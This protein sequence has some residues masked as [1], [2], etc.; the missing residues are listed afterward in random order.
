[1]NRGGFTA[2]MRAWL[3]TGLSAALVLVSTTAWAQGSGVAR[4]VKVVEQASKVPETASLLELGGANAARTLIQMDRGLLTDEQVIRAITTGEVGTGNEAVATILRNPQF[5]K[6]F[7]EELRTSQGGKSL[8]GCGPGQ[9]CLV[10][11]G[12]AIDEAA[13]G[14]ATREVGGAAV[15]LSKVAKDADVSEDLVA[16]YYQLFKEHGIPMDAPSQPGQRIIN[17]STHGYHGNPPPAGVPDTGGQTYWVKQLSE[18]FAQQGRQVIILARY[19]ENAPR[20][21]KFADNVWLVRIRAGGEDFVRKEEIYDLTPELSEHATAVAALFNAEGV[22]GHYADGMTVAAETATRMNVPLMTTSHSLGVAKMR[23]M[24][25]SPTNVGDLMA[26]D[27]NYFV[28]NQLEAEAM[29]AANFRIANNMEEADMW[30]ADYNLVSQSHTVVPGGAGQAFFDAFSKPVNTE[31][32]SEFGLEEGKYWLFWGRMSEAKNVDGMVRIF[33][34]ARKAN[35]EAMKDIKIAIIGGSPA[36]PGSA[37]EIAVEKSI[38]TAMEEYGL[39]AEDVVRIGN[40][41]HDTIA[42]LARGGMGYIGPQK[43]EPFGMGAAEAMATGKPILIS[44]EAGIARWVDDGVNAHVIDPTDVPGAANKLLSLVTDSKAYEDMSAAARELAVDNF[45]WAGIAKQ[46]GDILDQLISEGAS[47][48]GRGY[49]R[50]TAAWRGQV[51][52]ISEQEVEQASALAPKIAEMAADANASGERLV[53]VVGSESGASARGVNQAL[54]MVLPDHG[55]R[56]AVVPVDGFFA[57]GTADQLGSVLSQAKSVSTRTVTIPTETSLVE[58]GK[59]YSEVP[60]SLEGVDVILVDASEASADLHPSL[61]GTTYI[62]L[63]DLAA[64]SQGSVSRVGQ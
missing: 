64:G 36:N 4:L 16:E 15:D 58:G 21:E 18:E 28:R 56:G 24:A 61:R 51:V 30:A 47:A 22:I 53:V 43:V 31:T 62:N 19:F 29:R 44:K 20:V 57:N 42:D 8:F 12:K 9:T 55:V 1:M 23:R 48:G 46:Q 33:G 27:Y 7:L 35:P 60:V 34:E 26:D 25:R 14:A 2:R 54:G 39:T 11:L 52:Q 50:M 3:I 10:D 6:A 32:L 38:K 49:H 5:R 13:I 37:E 40:Q 63:D 17:V 59:A 45:S 41:N